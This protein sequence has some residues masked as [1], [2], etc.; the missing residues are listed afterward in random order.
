ASNVEQYL[1]EDGSFGSFAANVR[2]LPINEKSLFIRW[3]Y[4]RYYHPARLAGQRSTS[5]LQKMSVFLTDF[6]AGRYQNYTDL[7]TTNYIAPEKK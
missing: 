5:L 2:K 6:E 1:F 4:Q 3:V 7:I